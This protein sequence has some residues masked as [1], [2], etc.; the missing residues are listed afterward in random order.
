ML[1][2]KDI[3]TMRIRHGAVLLASA[4]VLSCPYRIPDWMSS[5]LTTLS[6]FLSDNHSVQV[7]AKKIF[8]EFKRTHNDTWQEDRQKF[9][10][11]ELDAISELLVAPSYYA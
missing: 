1:S 5:L 9:T 4:L 2:I 8:S 6:R 3:E 11:E 7:T 10:E